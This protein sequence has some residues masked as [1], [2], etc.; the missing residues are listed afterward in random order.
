MG[1]SLNPVMI[2]FKIGQRWIS[3]SEPE[4]GLGIIESVERYQIRLAFKAANEVRLYAPDNASIKR[5]K[6]C[7]G[8]TIYMQDGTSL[9]V[10]TVR[11]ADGLLTYIGK[12]AEVSEAMVADSTSFSKPED[13]LISGHTDPTDSFALRYEAMKHQHSMRKSEIA[14]FAG[15]RVELIP[16]QLYIASKVASRHAPRV[17]LADEVGLGK[18]IEACLILHRLHLTGRAERMLIVLPESLVHQWFV[19][20]LRRF[21]LWFTLFDRDRCNDVTV[22]NPES[23]PFL[24]EQLVICSIGSLLENEHLAR[25]AIAAEWDMLVVDEAHHLEWTPEA[26]SHGYQLVEALTQQSH[27]L[28][29]LTATPEQLGA[30]GH[31]ARLRLL[32]PDRYPDLATFK[33]EQAEYEQVANV[34]RQL[35]DGTEL[36]KKDQA[37]LRSVFKEFTDEEFD[38]HWKERGKL[39][40]ELV[41]RHGTGRVIFRNTR[42]SLSGFPER[43]ALSKALK[44]SK[45]LSKEVMHARLL[46]EFDPETSSNGVKDAA[47]PL[48]YRHGRRIRWLANLLRKLGEEKVLL[49]CRTREKV[50]AIYDALAEELNVKAAVFHEGLTLLQRDRNAAW[51]AE[52]EGAQILLCSEIGSEGRNFQFAHHLALFDLPLN[53]ELLEQRIGRLDRIGQTETVKV[54]LP[55]LKHSWTELLMRWHHEGLD[56]VE[57]SLKGGHAY[58]DKFGAILRR[59]GPVYHESNPEVL[60]EADELIKESRRFRKE[61]EARLKEGQDSLIAL[62]SF[63]EDIADDLV[64]QIRKQDAERTLDQ[65]M[66]RIYDHFGVTVE[67]LDERTVFL[68]PGQLFTDSFPGLPEEGMQATYERKRALGREDIGFLSWDHPMVRGSIDLVLSTEK[69]NSAMVVWSNPPETAPPI[70]IEAVYI[71]ESI[72]PSRLHVDR[73]LPP[74]PVRVLVDTQGQDYSREFSHALIN[75]QTRDEEAFHLRQNMELLRS[76]VP[77]M[78]KSALNCA[79]EQK[80]DLLK[81]AITEAH[82][83]LDGEATRLKELRKL[84]PNVRL[85]EIEIA[86]HVVEE[87]TRHIAEA[88]LRL[89]GVR[90]V[91]KNG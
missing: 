22:D 28:L 49:I 37:F 48:D 30:D 63:R 57:H 33:A 77:E 84:N 66:N 1:V 7:E 32:D 17:L 42:D 25:C 5:V 65:F 21:N 80:S 3:E 39:L 16:H 75:K 18:T 51:F 54:H 74:T 9:V 2:K 44:L 45:K 88:H 29:L 91:L 87:I 70:L 71:L 8:D 38:D 35:A 52:A 86:E 26:A 59:L 73:F 19:E 24:E 64:K 81:S 76:L 43:K 46:R 90:L 83:Q 13:R 34:A 31:F 27:G 56:G 68:S 62:N 85:Q 11:E 40:D 58:L 12:H 82:E 50:Q 78:L 61:L 4:L 89:D 72:A 20:L 6:F 15:G 53:P 60:Q 14:G 10:E 79:G 67:D 47:E 36:S 55:Y 41:D 69:G 23:N